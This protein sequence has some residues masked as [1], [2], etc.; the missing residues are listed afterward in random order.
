M[1]LKFI[2][3]TGLIFVAALSRLLP[4]PSEFTPVIA[5]C[6]FAGATLGSKKEAILIPILSMFI[7]DLFLGF[8]SLLPVVY[9][10]MALISIISFYFL[11][12][13]T[14]FKTFAVGLGSGVIFYLVTNFAV[15][16][17]SGMYA[18]NFAGL[19]ECYT[20]AIPFFRNSLASIFVYS[21]IL[22]S[23]SMLLERFTKKLAY[24]KV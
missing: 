2:Y 24:S 18:L 4:H 19:V 14:I 12:Q 7:S 21:A 20:L 5:I 6:I 8:H 15:W 3:L 1:N 16:L 23:S 10:T 13:N 17:S 9:G 22:F 11:K